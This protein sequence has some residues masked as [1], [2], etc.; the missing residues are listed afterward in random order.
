MSEGLVTAERQGSTADVMLDLSTNRRGTWIVSI[1][2]RRW[3][4][5]YNEAIELLLGE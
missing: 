5:E 1:D 2:G 4:A 3:V